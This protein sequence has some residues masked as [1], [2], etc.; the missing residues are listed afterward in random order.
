MLYLKYLLDSLYFS[1]NYIHR[2]NNT[3]RVSHFKT[4]NAYITF[5]LHFLSTFIYSVYFEKY[6]FQEN[7]NRFEDGARTKYKHEK[8]QSRARR[9][10]PSSVSTRGKTTFSRRGRKEQC[11]LPSGNRASE[12]EGLAVVEE[13]SQGRRA[14]ESTSKKR[15]WKK[16]TSARKSEDRVFERRDGR[17]HFSFIIR[18]KTER[19][20]REGVPRNKTVERGE[21][22]GERG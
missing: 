21:R 19:C 1:T 16:K 22:E 5:Y 6:K 3:V 17:R 11:N 4:Y 10:N 20:E 7:N 8:R 15:R 14:T 12:G 2:I 18:E 9:T 13:A